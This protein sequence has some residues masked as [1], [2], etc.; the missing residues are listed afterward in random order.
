[1]LEKNLSSIGHACGIPAWGAGMEGHRGQGQMGSYLAP[2]MG[3]SG[4]EV[5]QHSPP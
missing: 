4:H 5:T 3:L 1:M 2:G